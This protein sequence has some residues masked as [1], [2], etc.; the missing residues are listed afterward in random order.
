[1]TD[2]EL[3]AMITGLIDHEQSDV[4][5]KSYMTIAKQ[6]ILNRLYPFA[7]DEEVLTFPIKY[8]YK[9]IEIAVYLI[10]KRGAEGQTM[11]NEN[12]ILRMY[13]NADLPKSMLSDLTPRVGILR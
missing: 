8:Q 9:I 13:E 5:I 7:T 1:M 6:K 10:N 11:S 2:D 3:L 4:V 12:G